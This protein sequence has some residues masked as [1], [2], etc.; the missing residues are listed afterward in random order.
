[1]KKG[2]NKMA[3]QD[4]AT[5]GWIEKVE[6]LNVILNEG[7]GI[8]GGVLGPQSLAEEKRTEPACPAG[9]LDSLLTDSLDLAGRLTSLLSQLRDKF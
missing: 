8:I 3:L 2:A 4:K 1:M 9:R 7:H 6:K 5:D